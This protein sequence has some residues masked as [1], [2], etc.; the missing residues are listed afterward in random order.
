M[1]TLL[2]DVI[3]CPLVAQQQFAE[4]AGTMD[5]EIALLVVHGVLHVLGFDHDTPESA[6]DM[7]ARELDILTTHYWSGPAPTS[8]RQEHKE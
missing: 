8:F 5:D 7:R 1:P 3:V 6:T 4:H 2:G